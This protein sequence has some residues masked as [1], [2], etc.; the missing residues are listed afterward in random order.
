LPDSQPT[1]CAKAGRGDATL[2]DALNQLAPMLLP[3]SQEIGGLER[4]AG[5]RGSPSRVKPSKHPSFMKRCSL[6]RSKNPS[7]SQF[8]AMAIKTEHQTPRGVL[9]VSSILHHLVV[10]IKPARQAIQPLGPE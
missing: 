1:G 9:K 4:S 3:W 8:S 6:N 10:F 2:Q 7:F 5:A